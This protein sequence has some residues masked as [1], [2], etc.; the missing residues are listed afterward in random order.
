M[1]IF[2]S[3]HLKPSQVRLNLSTFFSLFES[4]MEKNKWQKSS[5]NF[6]VPMT[7]FVSTTKKTFLKLNGVESWEGASENEE[8]EVVEGGKVAFN[9]TKKENCQFIFH[10]LFLATFFSFLFISTLRCTFL[11]FFCNNIVATP[12]RRKFLCCFNGRL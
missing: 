12:R 1:E 4:E 7:N 11:S 5:G 3:Q 6:C 8:I 9:E 2:I 10:H